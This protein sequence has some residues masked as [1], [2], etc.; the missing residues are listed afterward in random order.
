MISDYLKQRSVDVKVRIQMEESKKLFQ[1]D[2]LLS[3]QV[4]VKGDE[5]LPK[6]CFITKLRI[7]TKEYYTRADILK[8][9][10]RRNIVHIFIFFCY[11]IIFLTINNKYNK[12]H[13]VERNRRS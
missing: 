7:E 3:G 10:G 6:E 1:E 5:Y 12:T 4:K 9:L 13:R 8:L 11:Y 2:K